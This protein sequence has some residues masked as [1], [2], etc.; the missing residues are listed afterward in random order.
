MELAP[1]IAGRLHRL[2]VELQQ[3]LRIGERAVLLGVRGRREEEHFGLDVLRIDGAPDH[4]GRAAPELRGLR[5]LDVAHDEPLQLLQP[6]AMER[7]IH[8]S[9]GRVLAHDEVAFELPVRHVG[10]GHH[11]RVVAGHGGQPLEAPLVVLGGVLAVPG[12]HQRDEV[13]GEIGPEPGSRRVGLHVLVESRMHGVRHRDVAGEQVEER[14]D[15]RR[16]LER[17]VT[18]QRHDAAAG[19]PHVA[20]QQL[21]DRG[22]ADVLHADGVLRPADRVAE[23]AGALAARVP[24]QLLGDADDQIGRDAADLADELR[25][26]ARIVPAQD[27]VDAARVLQRLVA[28]YLRHALAADLAFRSAGNDLLVTGSRNRSVDPFV[29]PRGGVVLALLLVPAA[30]Q[31]AQILGVLVILAD[32]HRRVRVVDDVLLE[33]AVVGENVVDDRAEERDV[34]PGA[35]R[36]VDVRHRAGARK[37]WIDVDDGGAALLGFHHPLEA[38]RVALRH[39]RALDDDDVGVHQI[40]LERRRSAAPER[41]PQTGDRRAVSYPRLVLDLHDPERGVE[42]LEEIVLLVV[43]RR[44]A[45]VRDTQRALNVFFPLVLL[46]P[47]A[48]ASFAYALGDHLRG[49]L[50]R[51]ELPLLP[52]RRTIEAVVQPVIAGNELERR[53]A[54]W[55]QAAARDG[56]VFVALD[57]EDLSCLDVDLLAAADGAVGADRLDHAVRYRRPRP[58]LV[59]ARRCRRSVERGHVAMRDLPRDRPAP[60]HLEYSHANPPSRSNGG[61]TPF[62]WC[63]PMLSNGRNH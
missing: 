63:P 56:G 11:V 29:L 36:H 60:Q 40:L 18:A 10:D 12:A 1:A 53:R 26:V 25:R 55:A 49:A 23:G 42:L 13:S 19:P 41:D 58:Q 37:A 16:S 34:R 6:L 28:L 14:G 54:L 4:L 24:A 7:A 44:A 33:R 21:D 52:A 3:A 46:L 2:V 31:A 38:D 8:R 35:D 32:D 20:E 61:G 51:D 5:Q 30:E 59:G 15:V 45:E 62:G 57:V 39:V 50:E 27:L 43:E 9:D 47:G 22:R 48:L 17:R